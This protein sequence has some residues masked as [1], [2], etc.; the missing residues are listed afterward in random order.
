MSIE[1][2]GIFHLILL[3]STTV[4]VHF[5]MTLFAETPYYSTQQS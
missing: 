1:F 2:Q 5:Y 4:C 3:F